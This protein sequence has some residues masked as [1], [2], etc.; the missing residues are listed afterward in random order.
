MAGL[1]R[2]FDACGFIQQYIERQIRGLLDDP[3]NEYQ[4]PNWVQAALLFER[5]VIPCERYSADGLYDLANDIVRKAEQNNNRV[6]FQR[7]AGM[8]N[9]KILEP[10]SHNMENLSDDLRIA[11]YD[12]NIE[13]IKKWLEEQDRI[14]SEIENFKKSKR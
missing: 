6:I 4:D 9:E 13:N 10:N 5:V 7:I 12:A 8:Y 11:E 1:D 3:M 2:M 14:N